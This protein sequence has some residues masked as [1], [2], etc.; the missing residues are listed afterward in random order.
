MT[1][2]R[3]IAMAL[4]LANAPIAFAQADAPTPQPQTP[5]TQQPAAEPDAQVDQPTQPEP[6]VQPEPAL[7]MRDLLVL[8]TDRYDDTANNPKLMPT[9]LFNPIPHQDRAKRVDVNGAYEFAPMPLGLITFQG[10]VD[11]PIKLRLTLKDPRDRFHAHWPTNAIQGDRFLQW[12]DLSSED[13]ELR[14]VPFA[15]QH[16]WLTSLRAGDDRVWLQ[17]RGGPSKERFI[18][19]DPS[20]HF[21]PAISLTSTDAEYR[22]SNSTTKQAAPPLSVFLRKTET[23]WSSD[24]IASPWPSKTTTI[25]TRDSATDSSATLLQALAP[26]KELLT[27][28]GYN[29]Q[30]IGLALQ[31][32]VSAGFKKSNMSLVY[33][34]PDGVIDEHI[35][36]QIRPMPDEIYRTTIVVVN[37]VDPDLSSVINALLDDLGSDQWAKRDRAQRELV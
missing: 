11:E 2:A 17:A 14:A 24:T 8:Q 37:N 29:E 19:Y 23:G 26:I 25:A 1:R 5:P 33:I 9:T 16:A 20:I 36:L 6:V 32:V 30:E 12:Q 15:D 13:T 35:R 27:S 34:L 22:L 4:L 28:R 3:S 21:T 31:M 10:E 18:L 7:V